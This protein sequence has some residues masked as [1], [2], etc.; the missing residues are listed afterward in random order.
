MLSALIG[1]FSGALFAQFL[2]QAAY[3]FVVVLI[4]ISG[5]IAARVEARANLT[6]LA[7]VIPQTLL[8]A[9]LAYAVY[10][11]ASGTIDL[12]KWNAGTIAGVVGVVLALIYAVP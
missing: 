6:H 9:A 3:S 5:L 7:A 10:W 8:F 4:V 11:F 12:S 2:I 1:F